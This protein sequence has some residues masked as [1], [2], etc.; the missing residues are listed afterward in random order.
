MSRNPVVLVHGY[1]D[2]AAAFRP[3]RD[4]LLQRGYAPGGLHACSYRTLTNEVTIRDIAEGF[5]RALRLEAGLGPDQPFDAVVHSTGMLVVRSWLTQ[6]EGR[7][8]R[9]KRLVALA[10]ATW[11]SP[12]AHRGRSWLGAIFKGNRDTRDPDFMEAGDLV[13]DA[14]ELGSRFTWDLAHADLLGREVYYGPDGRTPWVFVLCGVETYEDLRAVVNEPGMDGTVRWAGCALDTRKIV[15]DL[16]RR[17]GDAARVGIAPWTHVDS[18]LVPVAGVNHGTILSHPERGEGLVDLVARA[19]TVEDQADFDAW[20]RQATTATRGARERLR[21]EQWQQFVVRAV[22][23]RGDPV[24]DYHL[25]LVTAQDNPFRETEAAQVDVHAY[26][27]DPSL[28][29]FHLNLARLRDVDPRRLRVRVMA[30]SGSALVAYSG[31]GSERAAPGGQPRAGKWDAQLDIARVLDGD[32]RLFHPFTTT[33]IELRLNREPAPLDPGRPADL[34]R[35]VDLEAPAPPAAARPD[36]T[37]L[38]QVE[39][40]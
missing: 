19:L 12:L 36:P 5:E 22:D 32:V 18:P 16:T 40:G 31:H 23:E 4:L 7:R 39:A 10:P 25:Q 8:G 34:C 38:E 21:D 14:L 27:A 29:C 2:T 15:L 33:L 9:L 26:R 3:W 35:F 13:L 1:S 24:P 11:G 28:R 20:Q 30:S 6:Y 17:P 37:R